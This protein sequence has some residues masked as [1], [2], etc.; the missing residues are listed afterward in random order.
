MDLLGDQ[1]HPIFLFI[2]DSSTVMGSFWTIYEICLLMD[3]KFT[4]IAQS[5]PNLSSLRRE[6]Q[7][8]KNTF[9]LLETFFMIK[10][11]NQINV[12]WSSDI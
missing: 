3:R 7:K 6:K 2:R 9:M 10:M 4:F 12:I 11:K 8:N 5:K 1:I